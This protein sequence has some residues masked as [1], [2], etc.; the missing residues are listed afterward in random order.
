[1]K[2]FTVNRVVSTVYPKQ[3]VLAESEEQAIKIYN[4]MVSNDLISPEMHEDF[5][6]CMQNKILRFVN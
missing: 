2:K 4:D 5:N 3:T 6:P 1:M